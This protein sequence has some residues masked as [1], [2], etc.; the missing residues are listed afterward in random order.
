M[1]FGT[2]GHTKAREEK[3]FFKYLRG[4]TMFDPSLGDA[5]QRWLRHPEPSSSSLKSTIKKKTFSI[6]FAENPPN[7]KTDGEPSVF[8]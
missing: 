8:F 3:S 7:K 4:L 2:F 6:F 1:T 5:V